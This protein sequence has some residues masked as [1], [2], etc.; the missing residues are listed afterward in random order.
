DRL[1]Q[2]YRSGP[3][4]VRYIIN[5]MVMLRSTDVDRVAA[6]NAKAGELVQAGVVLTS[7]QGI[8]RPTYL[9]TGLTD[10]KADMIRE[11]LAEARS[12]AGTFAT[13]S[14]ARLKGIRR[15]NQGQFQ[16]LPR[17]AAPGISES[18]QIEKTIRVVSTIEYLLSD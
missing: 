12:A 17:D 16:I 2:A 15:A 4:D 18:E 6:A 9:F 8:S 7:D 5:R 14:G 10:V 13:G 11:A 3:V 1:A